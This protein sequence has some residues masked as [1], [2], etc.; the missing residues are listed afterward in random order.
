MPSWNIR[1]QGVQGQ[2]Q[3]TGT[4]ASD[5]ETAL[6]TMMTN[7][8]EAA[9]AAGTAVPGSQAFTRLQGPVAPGQAPPSQGAMGPVAAALAEYAE[10]RQSEYRAMA[11]RIQAAVTGAAIATREY[12][13]GDLDTAREA[14]DA[15]RAVDL[16]L[17]ADLGGQ[18]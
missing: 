13:E 10:E 9:Q 8:S 4:H 14:Q 7:L 12:V 18:T 16:D 6:T 5:L 17:L 15:A 11:E 2:L 3:V 1:P